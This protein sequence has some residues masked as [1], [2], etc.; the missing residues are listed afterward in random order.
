MLLS[1]SASVIKVAEK[2]P[3]NFGQKFENISTVYSS[4]QVEFLKCYKAKKIQWST[5][6]PY[7]RLDTR[8]SEFVAAAV[9]MR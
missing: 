1:T 8:R 2:I 4:V 6:T 7:I 3:G 9:V 5:Y